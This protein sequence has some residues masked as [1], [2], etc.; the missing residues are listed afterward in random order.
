MLPA[1]LLSAPASDARSPALRHASA[2]I[3]ICRPNTRLGNTL[4]M[5]PLVEEIEATLPAA[6]VE[7]LTACP[8]AHEVFREF[9][10]VVRVHQLPFRGARHPLRHL[11]TLLRVRRE[12]YDILIDPCPRS[13][14]GRFLTRHLPARLK[15]GFATA[16]KMKGVDVSVPFEG[17]PVHMGDYPVFLL[18][19]GLLGLDEAAAR[20]E[21][22]KLAVRL[23]E[24]E[25]LAAGEEIERVLGA[26][27]TGPVVAVAAHATGA[28][29]FSVDWWRRMIASLHI[30]VPAARV[31]EIRPPNGIAA[32]P[33]LPAYYSRRV[34]QVAAVVEAASCFVCADSG[35]MHL[36]AAT[37]ATT[38]GLFKVTEPRLY[39]PRRGMSC[40]VTASD[41]A[42]ELV[43]ERVAQ[44]LTR[45]G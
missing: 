12:R 45:A 4:L 21:T 30:R 15:L 31:I 41:S 24:T 18:R 10:S 19:R 13:W 5:T 2:T 44:L 20:A 28:K 22:P 9:P 17:A 35:L 25:R 29:R 38:V 36:G 16:H 11:L 33:E 43:A 3:L 34:R 6:R 40:A 26:V 14:T 32:L 23:T 7:I 37:D 27:G 8:A 1:E 39:A 42:P